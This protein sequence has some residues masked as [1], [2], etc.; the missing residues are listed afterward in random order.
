MRGLVVYYSRTGAT[1]KVGEAIASLLD[2]DKELLLDVKSRKGAL[3]YIRSGREASLKKL[4]EIK[5]LKKN[6]DDYDLIIIGTPIWGWNISSP[7]RTYVTANKNEFKKVAFF[8]TQ[9]G[10]G[11]ERAFR[12]M[13]KIIGKKAVAVLALK[14]KDVVNNNHMNKVNEFVNKIKR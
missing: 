13:K 6:P 5:K 12:E 11:A 2:F 9:G 4:A 8:C 14:T 10:S 7:I 1:K 3:G